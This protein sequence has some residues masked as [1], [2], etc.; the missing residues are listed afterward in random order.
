MKEGILKTCKTTGSFCPKGRQIY[1]FLSSSEIGKTVFISRRSLIYHSL[2]DDALLTTYYLSKMSR[3]LDNW[4]ILKTFDITQ[5]QTYYPFKMSRGLDYWI[6]LKTFHITQVQTYYPFKLVEDW[7]IGWN[8]KLFTL[9]RFRPI[10]LLKWV[11]DWMI[12]WNLTLFPLYKFRPITL[13][14]R[15]SLLAC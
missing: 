11:Q 12:G 9:Y 4:M 7:M 5:G 6:K 13:F 15:G 2:S 8:L 3:G 14:K 10:T 1:P